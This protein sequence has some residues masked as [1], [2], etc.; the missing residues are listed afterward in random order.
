MCQSWMGV[1]A[2]LLIAVGAIGCAQITPPA[3]PLTQEIRE[4][5]VEVNPTQALEASPA[6]KKLV[7]QAKEDLAGRLSVSV[8][9]IEL[10]EAQSVI[11]PDSSMGCPKPGM[12]YTQIQHD[13]LLIRLRVGDRIYEYHSGGGR[14]PFL[15][16]E[17]A[18]DK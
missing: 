6:S 9:D 2:G 5:S 8:D 1:A 12:A 15:C 13:G 3:S 7:R 11:W 4:E 18:K 16:E 10:V 14:P 17:A